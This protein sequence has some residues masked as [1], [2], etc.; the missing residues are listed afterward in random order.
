MN[1]DSKIIKNPM[2]AH[3]YAVK[4]WD[5]NRKGKQVLITI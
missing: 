4:E 2:K 1:I 5:V 3:K